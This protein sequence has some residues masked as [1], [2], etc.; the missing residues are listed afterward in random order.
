VRHDFLCRLVVWL[1][2]SIACD[3][4]T[5][6]GCRAEDSPKAALEARYADMKAAMARP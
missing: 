3:S 1:A 5:A 6:I 2:L 4:A